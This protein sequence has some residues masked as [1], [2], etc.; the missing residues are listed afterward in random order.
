MHKAF[1]WDGFDLPGGFVRW[2]SV[3][4]V[5]GF[6]WEICSDMLFALFINAFEIARVRLRKVAPSNGRLS[7][8]FPC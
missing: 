2:C 1:C 8:R 7:P 3:C 4:E 5:L 6:R